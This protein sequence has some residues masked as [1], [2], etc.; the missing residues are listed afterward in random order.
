MGRDECVSVEGECVS[1]ES[2]WKVDGGVC[3]CEWKV[4]RWCGEL[5]GWV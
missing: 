4:S 5:S 2:E 3:V 1:V